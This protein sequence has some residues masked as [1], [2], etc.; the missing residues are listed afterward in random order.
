MF[1]AA[2]PPKELF[3][4]PGVGHANLLEPDPAAYEYRLLTFLDAAFAP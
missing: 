2:S 3:L 4:I 1:A